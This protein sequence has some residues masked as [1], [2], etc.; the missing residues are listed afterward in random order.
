MTP[1]LDHDLLA[2]LTDAQRE[3]VEHIDG[4]MLILAGPGSGKTRVVT[5]RIANLL[6][7]GVRARSILALTFTNKAADEMRQRLERL[8][9]GEPVW[10]GTFHRFCARM[11]REHAALA[12]LQQNYT[13]YDTGDAHNTLK[14][15]IEA[16]ELD[17]THYTPQSLASAISWAKNNLITPEHYEPRP[18]HVT[19]AIVAKVYPK[20]QE[21]LR[22]SNAVDFDDLLMHVA[23]ILRDSPELRAELDA[24]FRYILVDEYQ[25]T[26]LAQYAIAR[27]L[28]ID[29]PNLAVTGDPDQSIYGWRGATLNNIL[30]FEHDYP[31]V[32]TVRL[33]QNW[34]STKAILRVADALIGH[35]RRRKPKEL[36]T[37]NDEGAPVRLITYA[38]HHDEAEGIAAQIAG[39][40]HSGKRQPKDIAV[41]YRVNA[42]SRTFEAALRDEGIPYQLV[43]GV[44]FYQ[45]KEIKDV[46][47]YLVLLN[48]PR[49]D[50]AFLRVINT[51]T[52]G[53]GRSTIDKLVEHATDRGLSLLDAARESGMIASLSKKSAVSVAKFVGLFDQLSLHALRPLEELLGHVL[54][55]TEYQEMLR[56]SEDAEDQERLAN[57]EELLTAAREFD[58]RHPGEGHLEEF[59]EQAS[60]V[61]DTDE[62]DSATDRVTLM[63]MHAA[64]GLEFPVVFIGAI[65]KGLVPHERSEH[66]EAQLEE[67][68][69]L[70][71]VGITR[72][73]ERLQ[74]S[75][76]KRR[77]FRG[78][79]SFT[80]P[81]PFLF[82]LPRDELETE[83][84]GDLWQPDAVD[85]F[86][87]PSFD[88][89]DFEEQTP[90]QIGKTLAGIRLMTAADLAGESTAS[91]TSADAFYQGMIVRHPEYGLG[92]IV[93]LSGTSRN[94][95]ATVDFFAS[96]GQKTFVLSACPLKPVSS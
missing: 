81:S 7:H 80:I 33:E 6:Q 70:L 63:T 23:L 12:G 54:S 76:A 1:A 49:D 92:K 3:A 95:R 14:R 55:G 8:A 28:S 19:G 71:F 44:E 78:R 30:E 13:I 85:P 32:H 40:I 64:K 31:E 89:N 16:V 46:L 38:T 25:D 34:R 24:R 42:L 65:E 83:E 15:A 90:K 20:Y 18:G 27:A 88:I 21:M 68:R 36:F 67:E 87:E 84:R 56:E 73:K 51:P 96:V 35:N 45:R 57:I 4:P 39:M 9:P 2:G 58:E 75:L 5:H 60:L 43:R 66:D 86:E 17:A 62:W 74:L 79:S 50:N 93:A 41:F 47:S 94:R 37:H 53:I 59:L 69:R 61:A 72:A 26:N 10:L 77:D 91:D 82:E 11:L 48:N 52:R 22:Q 29:Y